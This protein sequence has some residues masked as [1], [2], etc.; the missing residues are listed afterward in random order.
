[1]SAR[2][3]WIPCWR[4]GSWTGR[5]CSRWRPTPRRLP[6]ACAPTAKSRPCLDSS[7]PASGSPPAT[8]TAATTG[9]HPRSSWNRPGAMR[10][11]WTFSA[12]KRKDSCRSSMTTSSG[13]TRCP[14]RGSGFPPSPWPL[15]PCRPAATWRRWS[16]PRPV[17][18]NRRRASSPRSSA[19]KNSN[20]P[21]SGSSP[22]PRKICRF[23]CC[24]GCPIGLS[25]GAPGRPT[26]RPRGSGS[27]AGGRRST[28]RR[29]SRR[30]LRITSSWS[31]LN[32]G[33]AG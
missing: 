4:T 25:S 26:W 31:P 3:I 9:W 23:A 22:M 19:A 2:R 29:P 15:A 7:R 6:P 8:I 18:P 5:A 20:S 13:N 10:C 11:G 33:P 16:K 21:A 24:P 27:G 30:S 1:M 14:T 28:G 32:R 12:R 17:R